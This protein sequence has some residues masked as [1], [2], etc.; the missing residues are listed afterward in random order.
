[1]KSYKACMH[2]NHRPHL[3]GRPLHGWD[4]ERDSKRQL[5]LGAVRDLDSSPP[6]Q[7]QGCYLPVSIPYLYHG[8][9]SDLSY[10]VVV[11]ATTV[12]TI[13]VQC[14]LLHNN[15]LLQIIQKIQTMVWA[16]IFQG[17]QLLQSCEGFPEICLLERHC[18]NCLLP[19]RFFVG[20][21]LHPHPTP[22]AVQSICLK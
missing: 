9:N 2:R 16:E 7:A 15:D 20:T 10:R 21:F 8:N 18:K 5:S 12:K 13:K 17:C 14:S 3:K 1:M 4:K 6:L 11:Q 22:R 19:T